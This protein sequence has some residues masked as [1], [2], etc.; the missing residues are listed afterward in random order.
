MQVALTQKLRRKSLRQRMGEGAAAGA[1]R[2]ANTE[3]KPTPTVSMCR[4]YIRVVPL[5]C[6][7]AH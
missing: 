1:N 3:G 2:S 5:H 6:S 4:L 7:L